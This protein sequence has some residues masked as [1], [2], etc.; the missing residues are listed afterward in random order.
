MRRR[1][2][3]LVALATGIIVVAMAVVFALLNNAS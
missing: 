1:T 3:R 2:A